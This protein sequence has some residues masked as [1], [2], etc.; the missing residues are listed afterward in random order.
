MTTRTLY[1]I[2]EVRSDATYDEIRKSYRRLARL[3]HP[4]KNRSKGAAEEFKMIKAAYE[5]LS[6]EAKRR[7]YDRRGG[8]LFRAEEMDPNMLSPEALMA[9]LRVSMES[10][11]RTQRFVLCSVFSCIFSC[12]LLVPALICLRADNEINSTWAEAWIPLWCLDAVV[13]VGLCV[14]IE[15]ESREKGTS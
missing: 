10:T 6:D 12:F 5:M 14:G 4:D 13:F 1:D 15:K 11:T 8:D 9:T 2:L 7:Y 3:K